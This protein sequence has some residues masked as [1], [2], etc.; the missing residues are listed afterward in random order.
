MKKVLLSI[1]ALAMGATAFA[2]TQNANS[3]NLP[4]TNYDGW[5]MEFDGAES[6]NC[7]ANLIRGND[8]G[9]TIA[10]G[11]GTLAWTYASSGVG[12]PWVHSMFSEG[13]CGWTGTQTDYGSMDLGT[14]FD[15]KFKAKASVAVEMFMTVNKSKDSKTVVSIAS[16]TKS[17][18]LTTSYAEYTLSFTSTDK[19]SLPDFSDVNGWSTVIKGSGSEVVTIDWIEFGSKVGS[20]SSSSSSTYAANNL[21]SVY[22]N[23]ASEVINADL[24]QL[25]EGTVTL[26]NAQ[27]TV[28]AE[29]TG[30]EVVS[31]STANLASGMYIVT[32]NAGDKVAT[33]K[34]LVK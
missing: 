31:F 13:N 3:G 21:L 18:N 20:H 33:K 7:K 4:A 17:V 26:M 10:V 11:S 25:G 19:G 27:G 8:P 2:Q 24:T 5:V 9:Y 12:S 15:I 32:V 29:K 22:P 6:D 16:D 34:V 14:S 23:P 1:A 28:V 30:S